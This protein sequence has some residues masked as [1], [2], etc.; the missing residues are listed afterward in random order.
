MRG[1]G[2]VNR[3]QIVVFLLVIVPVFAE[4]CTPMLPVIIPPDNRNGEF[5]TLSPLS[6]LEW[7]ILK[8]KKANDVAVADLYTMFYNEKGPYTQLELRVIRGWGKPRGEVV[9]LIYRPN[10]CED[11]E[12][13]EQGQRYVLVFPPTT[14]Q[15]MLMQE[16]RVRDKLGALGPHDYV[17]TAL[18]TLP[19]KKLKPVF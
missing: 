2:A 8:L 4:A 17:Y 1:Q 14:Q 13:F 9:K 6:K 15:P 7:F 11:H 12:V 10:N 19:R 16:K 18:G 5:K 3:L